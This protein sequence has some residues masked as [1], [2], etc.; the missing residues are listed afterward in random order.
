MQ[1][2]ASAPPTLAV[3]ST[4]FLDCSARAHSRTHMHPGTQ[5]PCPRVPAISASQSSPHACVHAVQWKQLWMAC[6]R[7]WA[8]AGSSSTPAPRGRQG[9]R[10]AQK[11]DRHS[12]KMNVSTVTAGVQGRHQVP[13]VGPVRLNWSKKNEHNIL[14]LNGNGPHALP[15]SSRNR[16][17]LKTKGAFGPI[18]H[19]SHR[20]YHRRS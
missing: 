14:D 4:C 11:V 17:A 9:A 3:E 10:A 20:R 15:P 2:Q 19:T 8:V 6:P 5:A 12:S 7:D 18:M 13:G 1:Q 16:T